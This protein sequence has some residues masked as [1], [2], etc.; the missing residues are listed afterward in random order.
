LA[1]CPTLLSLV[2][3]Q[4]PLPPLLCASF[5]FHCLFSF[6]FMGW[7]ESVCPGRLCLFIPGVAEG[8][9]LTLGTHLFGLPEVSLAHLEPV[10]SG[11][12]SGVG[13]VVHLF[14]QCIMAWRSLPWARSSGCQSFN[15][16]WC[17]TSAKHGSSV[18]ARSQIHGVYTVCICVPVAIL[19]PLTT[20]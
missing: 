15:S 18:S 13:V 19:N 17:F 16:P 11:S 4:Q 2:C 7:G 12:G 5:Q 1:P 8:Y 20:L 10:A 6:F 14:S 9:C 3:F